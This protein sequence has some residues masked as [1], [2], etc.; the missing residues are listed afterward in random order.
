MTR[1]NQCG[2]LGT[3]ISIC[4]FFP[5]IYLPMMNMKVHGQ[6][7]SELA[8]FGMKV[9]DK[10][11]S[12]LESVQELMQRGQYIVAALIFGF[13]VLIP[14]IKAALIFY[15]FA[16]KSLEV[17]RKILAFI[18]LIGRWSMVDVFVVAI[19]LA[20][21]STGD[22]TSVSS[23]QLKLMGFQVDLEAVLKVS[24]FLGTGFYFF[25]SYCFLSMIS[26]SIFDL[27]KSKAS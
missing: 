11:S 20:Q 19:F 9:L 23:H 17:R 4:L 10:S 16:Q 8:N 1:R 18:K 2:L 14:L 25:L 6:V 27:S 15:G 21:L 22:Q 13:S 3:F 12:I 7:N 24:S 26:F 5:G